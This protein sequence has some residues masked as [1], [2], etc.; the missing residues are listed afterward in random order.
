MAKAFSPKIVS[1]NDLMSGYTIYL[2]D[3]GW[4]SD[5]ADAEIAH[6]QATADTLLAAAERQPEIAVGP[7]LV[8]V[9][10]HLGSD[11]APTK[12]REVIRVSGPT[13][14]ALNKLPEAAEQRAA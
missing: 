4:T 1:A 7:Y 6:D 2:G 12:Y 13:V 10:G 3:A 11:P 5:I 9:T 14:G 8:D